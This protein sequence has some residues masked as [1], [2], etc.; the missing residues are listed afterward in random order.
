MSFIYRCSKCR[1]RNTW[2][3]ALA[4]YKRG[5]KCRHCGYTK[6]YVDRERIERK[7]CHCVGYHH[8]HRPGSRRCDQHPLHPYWRSGDEGVLFDILIDGKG[9]SYAPGVIPF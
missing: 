5:R 9:K 4:T 2:P 6:F 8:A 3:R 7:P 1:T